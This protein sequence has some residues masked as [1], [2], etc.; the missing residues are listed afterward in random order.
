RTRR[1][2]LTCCR[3][4]TF[5]SLTRSAPGRIRTCD[6]VLRRHLL[7]PLS[8]GRWPAPRAYRSKDCGEPH[9]V[10]FERCYIRP[11]DCAAKGGSPPA[12]DA[13]DGGDDGGAR[14]GCRDG[15]LRV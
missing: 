4:R 1:T 15:R 2:S 5:S 3:T 13:A 8:Y 12:D 6:Q 7:Y 10:S 11:H 9:D 14:P